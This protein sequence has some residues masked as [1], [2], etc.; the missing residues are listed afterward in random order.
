MQE[1]LINSVD[2]IILIVTNSGE[3]VTFVSSRYTL[4]MVHALK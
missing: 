2:I 4:L 3:I 1:D